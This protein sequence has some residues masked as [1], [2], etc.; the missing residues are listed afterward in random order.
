MDLNEMSF[1]PPSPSP[2]PHISRDDYYLGLSRVR[3]QINYIPVLYFNKGWEKPS[4]K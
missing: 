4:L 2:G 1:P 3:V